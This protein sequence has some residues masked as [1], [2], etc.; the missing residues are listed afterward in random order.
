[1]EWACAAKWGE[2]V[3]SLCVRLTGLRAVFEMKCC[4]REVESVSVNGSVTVAI[5]VGWKSRHTYLRNWTY[6]RDFTLRLTDS[7]QKTLNVVISGYWV[8]VLRKI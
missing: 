5:F 2:A 3:L 4:I 1:M 7:P 8:N 6:S